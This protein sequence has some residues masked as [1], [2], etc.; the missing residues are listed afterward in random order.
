MDVVRVIVKDLIESLGTDGKEALSEN[1]LDEKKE[2]FKLYM[3]IWVCC[4]RQVR[5]HCE[6]FER[7]PIEI[8]HIGLVFKDKGI[9]T[10]VPLPELLADAKIHIGEPN[11]ENQPT[12]PTKVKRGVNRK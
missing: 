12:L 1:L 3:R 5:G 4:M 6:R 10:F 7:R 11:D 2:L 8:K 9:T